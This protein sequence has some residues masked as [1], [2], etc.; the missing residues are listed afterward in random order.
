MTDDLCIY[1]HGK[2]PINSPNIFRKKATIQNYLYSINLIILNYNLE[3]RQAVK[4][5]A[6]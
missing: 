4:I 5:N 6:N 1:T 3:F 2:L